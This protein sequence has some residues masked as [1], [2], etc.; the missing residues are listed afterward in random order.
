MIWRRRPSCEWLV[1]ERETEREV[2]GLRNMPLAAC[3]LP[4]SEHWPNENL[5]LFHIY[6]NHFFLYYTHTRV[7]NITRPLIGSAFQPS[8]SFQIS[9]LYWILNLFYLIKNSCC[10]RKDLFFEWVFSLCFWT[11]T[12]NITVNFNI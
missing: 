11:L 12:H 6:K 2:D 9:V 10:N 8:R 1:S 7:L 5:Q 3:C 4:P